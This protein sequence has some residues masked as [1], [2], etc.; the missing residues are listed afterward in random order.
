MICP[1]P[2]FDHGIVWNIND[3]PI[4]V[5]SSMGTCRGKR[6]LKLVVVID[7]NSPLDQD[8]TKFPRRRWRACNVGWGLWEGCDKH[9]VVLGAHIASRRLGHLSLS[10]RALAFA[11][12]RWNE[13]TAACQCYCRMPMI[14]KISCSFPCSPFTFWTDRVPEIKLGRIGLN[15]IQGRL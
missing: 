9:W 5:M 15:L 4:V 12:C 14:C 13:I 6:S 2:R 7:Q 10:L 3:M 1:P 8:W 11:L